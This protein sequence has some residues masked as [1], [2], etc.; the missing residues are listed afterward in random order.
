M[1]EHDANRALSDTAKLRAMPGVELETY[2][3]APGSFCIYHTIPVLKMTV[4]DIEY[5]K[6]EARI[7]HG[8]ARRRSDKR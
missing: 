1:S 6:M 8:S 4:D 3:A 5:R 7:M 2:N